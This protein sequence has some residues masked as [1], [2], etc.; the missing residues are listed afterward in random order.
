MCILSKD[1]RTTD[2]EKN[3]INRWKEYFEDMLQ[4]KQLNIIKEVKDAV[5]MLKRGSSRTR[6][7]KS[8]DVIKIRAEGN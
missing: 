5:K 6:R 8:E 2:H 7:N 4:S 3:I 1:G